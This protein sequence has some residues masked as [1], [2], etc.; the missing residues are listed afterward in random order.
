[1]KR[2]IITALLTLAILF[3]LLPFGILS[4]SAATVGY[5]VTGGNL[6][7]DTD[8]YVP[9]LGHDFREGI[10]SRYGAEDP[11]YVPPVLFVD[12]PENIWYYPAVQY[13]VSNK[14]MNGIGNQKFDPEGAMTRAMLVTVLWR[15]AGEPRQGSNSFTDVPNGLWYSDAVAWAAHNGIVSGIGNN[16]FDPDGKITREQMATILF[17]YSNSLGMITSDRAGLGSFPDGGKVSGYAKDALSWAV[18]EGLITGSASG[19]KV[20]LE[21]QGNATRAQV[22]TILMRYIENVVKNAESQPV[23]PEQKVTYEQTIQALLEKNRIVGYGE[24]FLHDLNADGT[25]ELIAMYTIDFA[26]GIAEL[27]CSV[28]TISENEVK[29]L[30]YEKVLYRMAGG[31]SGYGMVVERNGQRYLAITKE[32]GE[33]GE[34]AR[35]GGDWW[36]Y[37]LDGTS[38]TLASHVQYEYRMSG[39]KVVPAKSSAII[40]GIKVDYAE[41]LDWLSGMNRLVCMDGYCG[42]FASEDDGLSLEELLEQCR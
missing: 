31:P 33:T 6:Y 27:V 29:N 9:A 7:Y 4:A 42:Y 26:P 10:C 16:R 2:R 23:I 15:Y 40:D 1:M 18:A 28:Y 19:G 37:T 22:A 41:Y 38:L 36:L 21:P 35:R 17:R 12:V 32:S 5:P 11:N 25:Q 20:Y 30:L 14:L 3:A 39:G 34:D 13:A 8:Y 24:G